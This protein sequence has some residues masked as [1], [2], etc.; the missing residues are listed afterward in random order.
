MTSTLTTTGMVLDAMDA[1]IARGD[2]DALRDEMARLRGILRPERMLTTGEAGEMLGIRSVNTIK[3]MISHGDLRG[4]KQGGRW[5]VPISAV[6]EA[7]QLRKV[8]IVQAMERAM[9]ELGDFGREMTE[10]E[11]EEMHAARPGTY[12]WER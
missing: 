12:P 6:E 10:D 8:Q 1:A 4:E 2:L 3:A 7:A 5:L 9:D 11:M